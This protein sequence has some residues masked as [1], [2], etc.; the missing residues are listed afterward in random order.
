MA[1]DATIAL[2]RPERGVAGGGSTRFGE[3]SKW[4]V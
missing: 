3:V 4:R 2:V 1:A